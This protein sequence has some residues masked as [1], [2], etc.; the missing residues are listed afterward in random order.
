VVEPPRGG[1]GGGGGEPK[2]ATAALDIRDMDFDTSKP[3]RGGP[4]RGRSA[5]M[6]GR[7][8]EGEAA[9]DDTALPSM[10]KTTALQLDERLTA[11]PMAPAI[12]YQLVLRE[13][14]Q[15]ERRV[16]LQ[17]QRIRVGR[18]VDNDIVIL[19]MRSSRYHFELRAKPHGYDLKDLGGGNGTRLNGER[20]TTA[21]LSPGDTIAVGESEMVLLASESAPD[22]LAATAPLS[23]AE[24]AGLS[25][26]LFIVLGFGGVLVVG[27][28]AALSLFIFWKP[29]P[30]KAKAPAVVFE[31]KTPTA[32]L[33]AWTEAAVEPVVDM[34]DQRYNDA[35]LLGARRFL[36]AVR[37]V[38]P[39]H[40]K[41]RG[42]AERI[43]MRL[44]TKDSASLS[45]SF[46]PGVARRGETLII[47]VRLGHP[48]RRLKGR[49]L[50]DPLVLNPSPTLPGEWLAS[51]EI[52]KRVKRGEHEVNLEIVDL[53]DES[54]EVARGVAIR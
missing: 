6:G 28:L 54:F 30:E 23:D 27:F 47:K 15:P 32:D 7:D 29:T 49:F 17:G 5:A 2:G 21:K 14:G 11:E 8:A 41:A 36:Q 9:D 34:A 20:V 25:A 53:E 16:P 18:E 39:G 46:D 1:G 48:V 12:T 52:P 45:V 38:H 37:E 51:V 3:A 44:T 40:V 22:T 4:G 50:G 24:V 33:S 31:D 26:T 35:D 19:D 13:L 42:F 10:D 43:K